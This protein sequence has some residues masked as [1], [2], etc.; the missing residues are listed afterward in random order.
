MLDYVLSTLYEF[1]QFIQPWKAGTYYP[2]FIN[3]ETEAQRG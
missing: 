1:T 3:E 2:N